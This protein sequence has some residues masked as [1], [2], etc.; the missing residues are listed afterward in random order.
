MTALGIVLV[1]ALIALYGLGIRAI[2]QV[3][4]RALGILVG[5]MAFHNVVLMILLRLGTPHLLVRIVQAWKEGILLLL[6]GLALR[7][8]L[9]AWRAGQRPR[10]AF[11][12]WPVLAFA[13]LVL[14]YAVIPGRVFGVHVT[15]GQR[16][17]AVR[18]DLLL[19]GLYAFGRLFWTGRQRDLAWVAWAIAGSAAA[20]GLLAAIDL[21]VVPTRFWLDAGVNQLSSWLGFTYH[22]PRGLPENFFQTTSRG[23]LLRRAVSTYVSPLG[24]A[25]TGLLVVPLAIAFAARRAEAAGAR[26]NRFGLLALTALG[27]LLSVT[28]LAIVFMVME[29]GLLALLFRR[30][31]LFGATALVAAGAAFM[32][33]VYPQVG[34]LTDANLSP[35][36]HARSERI[37]SSGDP[38]LREHANQLGFDLEYVVLHPIGT[39]LGSAVH[40]F[41]TSAGPGESAIFDILGELGIL[42]GIL[43]LPTFFLAI[44]A[45]LL[46]YLKVRRDALLAMLPL[47]VSIGGLAL[48][49]ITLTSDVWADLS[50]TFLFWWAAGY[51]VS[52]TSSPVWEPSPV[53]GEGG[54]QRAVPGQRAGPR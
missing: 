26:A 32:V 52:T 4:F 6:L 10:L 11:L 22:G 42:G 49:L 5:G 47:V 18:L 46:A 7:L 50:V 8:C 51:S 23:Y 44:L 19:P 21:F 24:I 34:P 36:H 16:L 38:S 41:G 15:T 20:V 3:P 27:V 30:L 14:L 53:G 28:R 12:D 35:V 45:G 48:F 33:Y 40:R 39:G 43:Y 37:T 2:L 25:Y 9:L 13:A 17:L 1:L 54:R 31:W 29:F